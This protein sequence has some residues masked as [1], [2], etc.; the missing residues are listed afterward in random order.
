[1]VEKKTK[2]QRDKVKKEKKKESIGADS[3]RLFYNIS[4]SSDTTDKHV[5]N[6]ATAVAAADAAAPYRVFERREVERDTGQEVGEG[7]RH[8]ES[9]P[10]LANVP[11][12]RTP[13][14]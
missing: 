4:F 9:K 1:V 5:V 14:A 2:P 6:T 11:A 8:R 10:I 3:W 13:P 12:V 7:A